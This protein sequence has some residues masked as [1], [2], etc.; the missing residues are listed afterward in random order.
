MAIRFLLDTR[1]S[2]RYRLLMSAFA[3]AATMAAVPAPV[4]A[5]C[6]RIYNG[7]AVLDQNS[8]QI[9]FGRVNL[10]TADLQPVG[11]TLGSATVSPGTAVGINDET[12]LWQ[13]DLADK[14][15]IYEVFSTNGDDRVG[16]YWDIGKHDGLPGYFATW[17]PYVAIKQTHLKSGLVLTRFWQQYKMTDYDVVGN[18]IQIKPKHLSTIKADL[19]R[20]G[21][22]PPASG[23]G[24][25]FCGG[26]APAGG[27]KL[28]N[29]DCTQPNAYVAFKGPG[30]ESHSDPIG[31]DHNT[32][33][34]FWLHRNGIA[35]GMRNAATI[36]YTATCA[37]LNVTPV[38]RLPPVTVAQ[39]NEGVQQQV[40][41][42]LQFR[43]QTTP[44]KGLAPYESGTLP[45]QTAM[46]LLV[47]PAN[48]Q[49]AL[50]EG[51]TTSGNGV[52]YL[53]SDGYK[54]DPGVT[55][56]VGVQL[57][58]PGGQAI[59]F[60]SS[61]LSGGGNAA[62]WYPVEAGATAGGTNNGITTY[63][64]TLNAS[65]KR[66]PGKTVTPGKLNAKA[67]VVIRVQ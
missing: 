21:S 33:Y 61:D 17:F 10:T 6:T 18:K 23:S 42:D 47:A 39:L 24:S 43:C 57:S 35:F 5:K 51:V 27:S 55:T 66:L 19:V 16:G 63:T 9:R 31:S 37:V 49:S 58:Y 52:S 41:F 54:S 38:V 26:M 30:Y 8:A 62:G 28:Y 40:P 3:L 2:N 22:L 4:W 44:P 46:G 25:N 59:N 64:K 13:C 65:L 56:G 7:E 32:N 36:G 48:Y 67:Q 50:A 60:L 29:Y 15:E 53:L 11:T 34:Q 1:R 12:V 45:G 20:V 14:D